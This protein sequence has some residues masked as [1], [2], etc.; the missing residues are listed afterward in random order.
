MARGG[1]LLYN[2]CMRVDLLDLQLEASIRGDLDEAWRLAQILEKERPEDNRAAFNRGWHMLRRGDLKKGMELTERGRGENVFGSPPLKTDKPRWSGQP[3]AGKT[4]V[5]RG[6]GGFGDE[7]VGVRFAQSFAKLGAK[8]IATASPG[9]VQALKRAKGVS[10]VVPHDAAHAGQVQHDYW[11]P[12]MSSP[13]YLGMSYED[14]PNGPYLSADPAFVEKWRK[15]ISSSK[16]K[17][18]V[19]WSG[20]PKF[21]H[22]QQRRFPPEPLFELAKLPGVQLYSLQRDHDLRDLPPEIVDLQHSLSSWE[23]TAAALECLDLVITSCTSIAHMSAAM[24]KETWIIV[25]VLPYYLWA[26]PGETS[27]WYTSVRLFRQEAYGTWDAPLGAVAQALKAKLADMPAAA[28]EAPRQWEPAPKVPATEVDIPGAELSK[29]APLLHYAGIYLAPRPEARPRAHAPRQQTLHFVAGLPRSGS[30][31]LLTLLGQNPRIYAAPV[32][33]LASIFS[34]VHVNWD[35]NEFHQ[36]KPDLGAKKRVLRAMLESYHDTDRPLLLDKDRHWMTCIDLLEEVLERPVKMILPVRPVA[37][38]MASFE[39]IR[40]AHPLEYMGPDEAVGAT[41]TIATRAQYFSAPGGAL[42]LAYNAL[43]DAVTMGYL[44]RMLFVDYNKLMSAPRAQLRRIY[45]FLEEPH[46][47]HDL[48]RV[49]QQHAYNWKPHK[50]K[51]LH[52]VRPE[53][54]KDVKPA[55]QILGDVYGQYEQVDPWINW[56]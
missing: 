32:S 9:I 10:D 54:K 49:V 11:M 21:E 29:K 28:P 47:E 8:V 27:P 15:I 55:R 26:M 33:G 44:D 4:L 34:G 52:D 30:T 19:R 25:P 1:Q 38:I 13:L 53:F 3:L 36:E 5:L 51:G 24:G 35:K 7:V 42:G 14:L 39:A 43:K 37:E 23:D 18:G 46:F 6:E 41:S 50:L 40:R 22:E 17:V 20:N 56:T 12:A 31:A 2:A 16:L 48:G 45:D